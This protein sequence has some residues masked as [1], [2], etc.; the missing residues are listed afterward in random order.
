MSKLQPLMASIT[1]Q[2]FVP[3]RVVFLLH[4]QVTRDEVDLLRYFLTKELDEE[5]VERILIISHLNSD[6]EPGHWRGYDRNY[7]LSHAKA[8]FV[9]MIDHDNQ[10]GPDLFEKMAEWYT[11]LKDEYKKISS[12][13]PRLC[14]EIAVMYSLSELP[15]FPFYCPNMAII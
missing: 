4:K 1:S 13:L 8:K 5:W 9:F 7:L 10:F 11:I 15:H 14:E 12:S 6:Y 3:D 2:T